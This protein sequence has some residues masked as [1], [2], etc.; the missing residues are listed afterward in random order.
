MAERRKPDLG[1]IFDAHIKHEF[2]DHDVHA[3]I[4]TMTSDPYVHNVPT[5]T[6]GDGHAGEPD[7]LRSP[8]I[9]RV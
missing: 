1:A 9:Y 8:E 4:N 7:N 6:G 2:V 5:L 3:T